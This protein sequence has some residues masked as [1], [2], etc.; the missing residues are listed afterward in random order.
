MKFNFEGK[1]SIESM[2]FAGGNQKNRALANLNYFSFAA[3]TLF[4]LPH[5]DLLG[6]WWITDPCMLHMESAMDNLLIIHM[7]I[8]KLPIFHDFQPI[9]KTYQLALNLATCCHLGRSNEHTIKQLWGWWRICRVLQED[10]H[11]GQVRL[12]LLDQELEKNFD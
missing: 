12:Y 6:S 11:H 10:K 4:A 9:C 8:S 5:H 3:L 1:W 7:W 2:N